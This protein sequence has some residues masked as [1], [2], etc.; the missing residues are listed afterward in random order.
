MYGLSIGDKAGDLGWTLAFFRRATFSTTDISHTFCRNA[1]KFGS[2]RGRWPIDT[3]SPNFMNFGPG[4]HD[5]MRQHTSVLH[6]YT[7]KVVF[8]QLP[9]VCR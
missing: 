2:V 1:M 9:Y 4:S 6:W 8:R 3:Y 5:T 7:C